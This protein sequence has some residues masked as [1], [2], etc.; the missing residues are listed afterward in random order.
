MKISRAAIFYSSWIAG[1]KDGQRKRGSKRRLSPG[2]SVLGTELRVYFVANYRMKQ[3]LYM[4]IGK[5]AELQFY[6]A[7]NYA[8]LSFKSIVVISA[9]FQSLGLYFTL[10]KSPQ[11]H[12]NFMIGFG[13]YCQGL[14]SSFALHLLGCWESLIV[15]ASRRLVSAESKRRETQPL[16]PFPGCLPPNS[17]SKREQEPLL[18]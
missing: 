4:C 17:L 2:P 15:A 1:G 5:C 10:R 3:L 18:R 8:V 14:T 13:C 6:F 9:S 7:I 11:D 12:F 16:Y